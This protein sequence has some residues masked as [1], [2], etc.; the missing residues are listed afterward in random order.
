MLKNDRLIGAGVMRQEDF[1]LYFLPIGDEALFTQ[2]RD[3]DFQP[4]FETFPLQVR[5]ALGQSPL[6]NATQQSGKTLRPEFSLNFGQDIGGQA[7][8]FLGEVFLAPLA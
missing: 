3:Q 1:L 5:S 8:I 4:F 7:M 6:G 2:Y